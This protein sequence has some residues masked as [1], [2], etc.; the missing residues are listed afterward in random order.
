M[1]FAILE[2]LSVG[3]PAL[4]TPETNLGDV[5]QQDKA[6]IVVLGNP[7]QIAQGIKLLVDTT[8]ENY[9]SMSNSARQLIENRFTWSKV[10][11][12]MVHVYGEVMEKAGNGRT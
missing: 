7:E 2:A 8:P 5:V 3:C 12:S 1:P 9:T 11:Q 6:G 10:T 4:I